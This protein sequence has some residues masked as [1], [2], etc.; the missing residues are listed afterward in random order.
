MALFISALVSCPR[1]TYLPET[2][3]IGPT[4][5]RDDMESRADTWREGTIRRADMKNAM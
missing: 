1:A 4:V 3:N 5:G 2:P